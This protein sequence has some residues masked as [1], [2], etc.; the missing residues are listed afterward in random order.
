MTYVSVLFVFL[1]A[2]L[3][4]LN[5]KIVVIE[6]DWIK[7]KINYLL[8]KYD[9]N[10]PTELAECL[11]IHIVYEFLADVQGYY[12]NAGDYKFIV[13]NNNLDYYDQRVVI[14]HELGHVLLH[15]TLNSSFLKNNTL[16]CTDKYEYQANYFAANLLLPDG[17]ERDVDFKGMTVEQI[18]G[19]VGV[20]V[21]LVTMKF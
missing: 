13:V 8:E 10:E 11:G 18:A 5:Y 20:P 12:V 3:Y 16:L 1:F 9:T 21:E 4:V 2:H 14:A 17:F 6:M 15:P 19:V 7:D